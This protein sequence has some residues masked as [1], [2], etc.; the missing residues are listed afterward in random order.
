M[1]DKDL[2]RTM[3]E[4][5][6]TINEYNYHYYVLDDPLVSDKEYDELYDRLVELEKETG[7]VLPNSPTRRVGGEILAGFRPHRHL[8][9][10]WSLD[11]AKTIE[12][13][14]AWEKRVLKLIEEYNRENRDNPLPPPL[15]V[16]ENK[17]DGLTINLTYENGHLVQAATRGDGQ[18]G[19]AILEQVKTIKSVP[20]SIP[21]QGIIEVQGEGLMRLSVLQEYNET[22]AEPLKNARNAAAGALRNLDP[23]V[24]AKRKLDAYFYSVGYHPGLEFTSHLEMLQFLK[25][26]RFPVSNYVK[27]FHKIDD[28]A[29]EIKRVQ[30]NQG[31][32]DFLTDGLV[33]KINDL[34]TRQVLGNTIKFPRWAIAYK[35]PASEV[36]T[37][38]RDVIWQVGRTGKLTPLALLEPVDIGGVTVKRATLNNWDDLQRKQVAKGCRVWIRRSNDVIPEIMGTVRESCKNPE[39]IKKPQYCPA[40]GSELVENGAHLFC[41]NSLSCKPQLVSRLVHFASRNAMD[42]ETFSRK[43]A[44]QLFEEL[45][46]RDIADLYHLKYEDLVKL[47][48]F[49]PK[50]AQNLLAAIEKS[51]ECSLASFLFALGI[52]NVG[53]KTAKDLAAHFKTL[54]RVMTASFEELI[55]IPEI[56][57]VVAKSIVNF[58][59]DSKI[60]ESIGRLL[61]AGI[62]PTG[63]AEKD[64][65][66]TVFAGKTFVLT[67]TLKNFTRDEAAALIEKYGGKVSGSVSKK[68]DYVL[69]GEKAGSK[70]DKAMQ[71]GIK[72]IDEEKFKEMLE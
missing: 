59:S 28:M 20:L 33:I 62:R 72:V 19:E 34:R 11:K 39:E 23:K 5:V 31:E 12:E 71:L 2:L 58:F 42:I 51:K 47:E 15:Y 69:A 9:E 70:L 24:T 54:D 10:L 41:P 30:E 66:N 16:V 48:R 4:M 53:R 64:M 46:L 45:G 22:A 43:T 17:F 50:K 38:L 29:E 35:F 36:T 67:G 18:V 32:N 37:V 44:E 61:A 52:P 7:V 60:R 8:A 3:K 65:E 6:E 49:G 55:Q 57:E 68:T 63:E 14:R 27:T 21:Y 25:D 1:A 56:G 40:C 13:L 26:N